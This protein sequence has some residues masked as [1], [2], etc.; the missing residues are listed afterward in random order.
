[1]EA[2]YQFIAKNYTISEEAVKQKLKGKVYV[3]FIVEKDGSLSDIKV[4][5]DIGFGTGEE[6][7]RVMS[8]CPKWT[9]GKINDEPV[10]VM[11]SLPI[12]IQTAG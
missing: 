2:F 12:T 7:L 6:A 4:L 3:T 10:R 11:Y 8:I 1:M 9:P 5:R